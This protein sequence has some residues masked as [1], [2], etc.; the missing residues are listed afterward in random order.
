ML[1]LFVNPFVVSRLHISKLSKHVDNTLTQGIIEPAC[2]PWASNVVLVRKK[3]GSLRCCIDYRQL[4]AVT[5]RMS[6][7]FLEL[8]HVLTPWLQLISFQLLI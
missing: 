2:S 8:T 4:N 3:D 5:R 6:T 1:S 7:L